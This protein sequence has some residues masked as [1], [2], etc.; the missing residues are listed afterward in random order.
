M[1]VNPSASL[2]AYMQRTE[3]TKPGVLVRCLFVF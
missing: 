3:A 2:N 1:V